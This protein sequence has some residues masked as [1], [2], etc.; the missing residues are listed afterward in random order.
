VRKRR[1]LRVT[2][3]CKRG[4]YGIRTALGIPLGY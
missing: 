3:E 2:A 1:R 4:A